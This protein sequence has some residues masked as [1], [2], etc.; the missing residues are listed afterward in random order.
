M[1]A[2][3]FRATAHRPHWATASDPS[4]RKGAYKLRES[5]SMH[6]E[7]VTALPQVCSCIVQL[8]MDEC[9]HDQ[10]RPPRSTLAQ[11]RCRTTW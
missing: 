11:R 2:S 6:A 1:R 4:R 8:L 5:K 9:D 3:K 7:R 10:A